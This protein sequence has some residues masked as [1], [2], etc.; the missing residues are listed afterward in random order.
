MK[1]KNLYVISVLGE[2]RPGLVAGLTRVL[3]KASANIIDIDQSVLRGLFAMFMV[4]DYSDT[5]ITSSEINSALFDR[6]KELN[7]TIEIKPYSEYISKELP[8][9]AKNH[10]IVTLLG[11]DK[12]GVIYIFSNLF[13]SLGVNIERIRMIARGEL[14]VMEFLVDTRD[15]RLKDQLQETAERVDMDIVFQSKDIFNGAKRMVVFDMDKTLVDVEIIDEIA[16][17]AGVETEVKKITESAMQGDIEFKDALRRRVKLL[18]GLPVGI[19]EEIADNIKLTS[20]AEDLILTLKDL[21]YKTALISGGF[22]FFTEKLREKFDIDY[23]FGNE[24]VVKNGKLTGEVKEPI[25][26]AKEKREILIK[27]AKMENLTMDE[28]IAIG[29]GANDRYMIDDVG[30]GIAFNPKG[31]LK[32]FADGVITQKNIAGILYCLGDYREKV[33]K[34]EKY[35]LL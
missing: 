34:D 8:Q 21:G 29:D 30:L 35:K 20:G 7:T 6:A 5:I 26:D 17:V 24:L 25:I 16:R 22:S 19:L 32:K 13:C 10:M 23:A 9:E 12:P 4:V 28:I 2:D 14:I 3:A 15:V 33:L 18:K 31:V 27:I 11:K 1:K